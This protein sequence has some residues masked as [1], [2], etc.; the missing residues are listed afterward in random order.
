MLD[1]PAL[2]G[3]VSVAFW[4]GRRHFSAPAGTARPVAEF[5]RLGG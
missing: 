1:V 3:L 2:I 5:G 4:F